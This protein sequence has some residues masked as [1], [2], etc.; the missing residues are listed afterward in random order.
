MKR[1]ILLLSP[2]INLISPSIISSDEQ[3]IP[4]VINTWDFTNATVKAWDVIN[5]QKKSA[6]DAIVKGCSVCEREQCDGTV[7]YGGS[8]NENGETCL[9]AFLMDGRT[10]NIGA[11][12]SIRNIKDAIAVAKHVLLY[13]KHS[14]L[15][16]EQA[17]QFALMMGFKKQSL[18][19]EKSKAM[20]RDWKKKNCQPNFWTNVLPSP[21]NSCGPYVPMSEDF[22]TSAHEYQSFFSN[23]NHD[24][25]G[26]VAIDVN[27]NIATGTST[28][29]VNHKIPGRVGDSPIPGAG[30]YADNAVGAAA[31][32]GD[33]DILMRFLPS[34]LAVE[35]MRNGM[36]PDEAGRKALARISHHYPKFVGA[37]VV[38]DKN[39]NYGAACHGIDSFPFSVYH[40]KL[41]NVK[42]E[43]RECAMSI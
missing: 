8:P 17:T 12:G 20:H 6:I 43:K 25:I 37:I 2:L 28:N 11:V 23:Y 31:A 32:T 30:G 40:S 26:M 13:T 18:S 41:K 34:M 10:M 21:E 4:I 24:T 29:G 16:G 35:F 14:L 38:V 15:V 22:L 36:T 27:G 9:D 5:R 42:V 3:R 19:T 39:G 7:G 1:F 33:G